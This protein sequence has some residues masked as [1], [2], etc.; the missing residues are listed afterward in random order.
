MGGDGNHLF[1]GRG[2]PMSTTTTPLARKSHTWIIGS[3]VL[4]SFGLRLAL[5]M[6]Y[7]RP[8]TS[9]GVGDIN[10]NLEH[11]GLGGRG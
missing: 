3:R 11:A 8:P 10:E 7:C 5:S 6:K 2:H 1:G 4:T 9:I